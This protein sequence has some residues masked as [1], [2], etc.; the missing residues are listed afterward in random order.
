MGRRAKVNSKKRNRRIVWLSVVVI[1]LVAVAAVVYIAIQANNVSSSLDQYIN[2]AVPASVLSD[3][4]GVNSSTLANVG[5]PSG[6]D[7]PQAISGTPLTLNGKP[8][9]IYI[10]GEYCPFCAFE[11]WAMVVAFSKFG[12]FSGVEYMLSSGSDTNAN[13]PTFT[14]AGNSSVPFSYT[15][16]YISFLPVEEFGR[17]GQTDIRQQLTSDQESLIAQYD[18]GG[19]IPFVDF[20]NSYVLVG[21]QSSIDMSGDN[22]T[23]I[24]SQLN[25]PSSTVAQ[26]IDGAANYLITAICKI[27]G[28][29]PSSVCSQSYA[30]MT[31]AYATAASQAAQSNALMF[32]TVRDEPRWIN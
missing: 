10:G 16:Q 23:Q 11:R 19:S 25:N 4:T 2:D 8:E 17:G 9:V 6:V 15:S 20:A 1:A 26:Q 12:T 24:A 7:A 30:D 18:S 27:D 29:Q 22:W 5:A 32:A 3:L 31:L 21:A 28:A 13:T 14:F